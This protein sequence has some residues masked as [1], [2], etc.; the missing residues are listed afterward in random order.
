MT[1]P[2]F[3]AKG[4]MVPQEDRPHDYGLGR[5]CTVPDGRCM[6]GQQCGE[7]GKVHRFVHPHQP[8]TEHSPLIL[9]CALCE[10]DRVK[11]FMSPEQYQ[12]GWEEGLAV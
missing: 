7:R 3:D 2:A 8:E 11:R 4:F 12:F 6:T 10:K 1:E 5:R 9:F